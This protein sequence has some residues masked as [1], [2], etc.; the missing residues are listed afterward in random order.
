LSIEGKWEQT[1]ERRSGPLGAEVVE[2]T[3]KRYY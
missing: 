1:A 3:G 2:E